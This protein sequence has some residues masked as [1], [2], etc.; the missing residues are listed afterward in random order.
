MVVYALMYMHDVFWSL[1][2]VLI[3]ANSVDPDK[4]QHYAEF[5]LGFHC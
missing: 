3:I 5:H 2:V 1:K 4:M